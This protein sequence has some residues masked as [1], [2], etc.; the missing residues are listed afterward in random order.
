MIQAADK[1]PHILFMVPATE[2]RAVWPEVRDRVDALLVDDP[3][4]QEDVFHEILVGNAYLW[5]TADRSGFV[6]LQILA[7]AYSRD[8]HVWLCHNG[9]GAPATAYLPQL[10]ELARDERHGCSRVTF[11]SSRRGF[12]R[13]LPGVQV[14]YHYSMGVDG[15]G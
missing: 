12:E 6:V 7:T 15:D 9:T 14:E 13:L 10:L 11:R 3:A 4:V 1:I 5:T 2:F 8:L